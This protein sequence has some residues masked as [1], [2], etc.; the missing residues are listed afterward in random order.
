MAAAAA[1]ANP[2]QEFVC[3][4]SLDI[5]NDP[6]IHSLCGNSMERCHVETMVQVGSMSCPIC[7]GDIIMGLNFNPN[8]ALK[9]I[10]EAYKTGSIT[11]KS[12]PVEMLESPPSIK[13]IKLEYILEKN[14]KSISIVFKSPSYN[15]KTK[16]NLHL[17][18]VLDVSGSMDDAVGIQ[19]A[20]GATETNGFN[21]LDIAKHAVKT[22]ANSL[23]SEDKMTFITFSNSADIIF[24]NM[25][26][27]QFD[28]I[29]VNTAIDRQQP[30]GGTN[31]WDALRLAFQVAERNYIAGP[32]EN[33]AIIL[34]T[35]GNPTTDPPGGYT[36]ALESIQKKHRDMTNNSFLS[37]VY[38]LGFGNAINSNLLY[39]I[40]NITG[41]TFNFIPDAGFVGTICCN[42]LA[43]IIYT[44][45]SCV[46]LII[47]YAN[48]ISRK[49]IIGPIQ[50]QHN[51][52]EIIRLE[53]TN[54]ISEIK[55]ISVHYNFM[56]HPDILPEFSS[57]ISLEET[58]IEYS[59][60]L[61]IHYL[62]IA[63][64]TRNPKFIT[65][66]IKK[67]DL[68][69][70]TNV[71]LGTN[72]YWQALYKEAT[73]EI[74]LA[75]CPVYFD[76]WGQHYI[77]SLI[78][79][80]SMQLRN[81][82]KD[83][84]V[85][86]YGVQPELEAIRKKINDVFNGLPAPKPSHS[87]H[88]VITSFASYNTTSN[89]CFAGSS[90]VFATPDPETII[91]YPKKV[92]ELQIGDYVA[93]SV[94]MQSFGRISHI[95]IMRNPE[96]FQAVK[97]YDELVITPYH[98]VIHQYEWR[99]PIDIIL[100]DSKYG[101]IIEIHEDMYDIA[102]Y[103]A[104]FVDINGVQVITLGHSIKNDPIAFHPYFGSEQIL[105]D[106]DDMPKDN[107]GRAIVTPANIRRDPETQ[108]I[109]RIVSV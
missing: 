37:S 51:R 54:E 87:T 25:K 63:F 24:E 3:P 94:T 7:R 100:E 8:R 75:F 71:L 32:P 82:F 23:S 31:I 52:K 64:N 27:S 70:I 55:S 38:T 2:P 17:I 102:F 49:I 97:L 61:F 44:Y 10:I 92:N 42:L 39:D 13:P 72:Q 77:R 96:P 6:Y 26:A 30:S 21:R 98:P 47:Q 15:P 58:A 62:N 90:I 50:Y 43:N 20:S 103:G 85:Q 56:E 107:M 9:A 83:F 1:T 4:I 18:C 60:H 73:G 36:Y 57:W 40:S 93:T 53:K 66:F 65:E 108:L 67:M 46:N 76:K 14:D 5:M 19:T 41:G 99:F 105:D 45:A 22:F 109:N 16:P 59:R 74:S 11:M 12:S 91:P 101:E 79:A 84:A 95:M 88:S 104:D 69:K 89:G 106:L 28:R 35:D 80:H 29:G 68:L 81:N 34:L 78:M 48:G 86:F 33:T